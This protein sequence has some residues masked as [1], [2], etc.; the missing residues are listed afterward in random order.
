MTLL[1][2]LVT[3]VEVIA[4]RHGGTARGLGAAG[5]YPAIRFLQAGSV[6]ALRGEVLHPLTGLRRR[7]ANREPVDGGRTIAA[8]EGRPLPVKE[9]AGRS[10]CQ[11]NKARAASFKGA[12]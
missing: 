5:D 1:R 3:C 7:C 10:R 6:V 2:D 4:R 8:G 9:L 11:R 12:H